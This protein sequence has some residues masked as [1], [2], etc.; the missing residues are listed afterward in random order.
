MSLMDIEIEEVNSFKEF[1]DQLD[2]EFLIKLYLSD[3]KSIYRMCVLLSLDIQ[4][5][6]EG[7]TFEGGF[8]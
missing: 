7:K 1:F 2:E 8:D 3:P 4:L 6:I 5:E